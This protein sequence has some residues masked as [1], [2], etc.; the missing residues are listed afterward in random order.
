MFLP[1][2]LLTVGWAI[3]TLGNTLQMRATVLRMPLSD[4]TL[5]ACFAMAALLVAASAAV[6]HTRP[7]ID[8]RI[9]STDAP[10]GRRGGL[11]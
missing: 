8:R 9:K 1:L 7:A 10:S 2:G 3:L 11:S 6:F 5:N 4:V